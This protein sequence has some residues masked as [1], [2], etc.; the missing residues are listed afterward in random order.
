MGAQNPC[1]Q[2]CENLSSQDSVNYLFQK[3]SNF[4]IDAH[5]NFKTTEQ[6]NRKK[7]HLIKKSITFQN[8]KDPSVLIQNINLTPDLSQYK[9]LVVAQYRGGSTLTS[10]LFDK[11]PSVSY[12]FEPLILGYGDYDDPQ[13]HK[14]INILNEIFSCHYPNASQYI[15]DKI[16]NDP[17]QLDHYKNGASDLPNF[18]RC[19]QNYICAVEQSTALMRPPFCM[20]PE[21][22]SM[23]RDLKVWGEYCASRD[24]IAVK[25]IRLENLGV[26][27]NANFIHKDDPNFKIVYAFRD[28]RAMLRWNCLGAKFRNWA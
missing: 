16:I 4:E 13:H 6:Y 7:P 2:I 18:E 22:C 23:V 9:I 11:N 3:Y 28:P 12:I 17:K 21:T 14:Q 19:I 20:L 5:G 25:T 26:L 27:N 8:T 10:S 1:V 24:A 15:G